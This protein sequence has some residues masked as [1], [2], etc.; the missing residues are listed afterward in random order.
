M[1]RQ[2]PGRF[3]QKH[4]KALLRHLAG[5]HRHTTVLGQCQEE[6]GHAGAALVGLGLGL[7]RCSLP[8]CEGLPMRVV[9]LPRAAE[10]AHACERGLLGRAH[11][12]LLQMVVE[13]LWRGPGDTSGH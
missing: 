9:L 5:W 7:G 10:E 12:E 4:C 13:G 11:C 6:A 2:L 1:F 3:R 8:G